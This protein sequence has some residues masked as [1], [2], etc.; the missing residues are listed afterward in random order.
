MRRMLSYKE[1]TGGIGL[2]LTP[3]WASTL[4]LVLMRAYDSLVSVAGLRQISVCT[5]KV[6]N[7]AYAVTFHE[8]HSVGEMYEVSASEEVQGRRWYQRAFAQKTAVSLMVYL[9]CMLTISSVR[10]QDVI[11]LSTDVD[12]A[13]YIS[14]HYPNDG[15]LTDIVRRSFEQEGVKLRL[16]TRPWPRS[17]RDVE[18]QKITGTFAWVYSKERADKFNLSD[19]IYIFTHVFVSHEQDFAFPQAIAGQE[20]RKIWC[21]PLGWTVPEFIQ[22]YI[23]DNNL[24]VVNPTS[25]EDCY[26]LLKTRR[27][28]FTLLP[29]LTA[30]H[31]MRIDP[32]RLFIQAYE[33]DVD[34]NYAHVIF[35]KNDAGFAAREIFNRGLAKLISNGEYRKIV[36]GHLKGVPVSLQ[37]IVLRNMDRL[38]ARKNIIE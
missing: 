11:E 34:H 24:A 22:P 5:R 14:F 19:V 28:D 15:L 20:E 35:A 1:K 30:G 10:A 25:L 27:A 6:A 13:P 32:A 29:T 3:S 9:A 7:F 12:F 18:H 21:Y 2:R 31:L 38:R 33:T 37:E 36:E 26:Q 4:A 16:L 23:K 17:Y 8:K